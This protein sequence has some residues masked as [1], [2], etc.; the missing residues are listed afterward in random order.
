MEIVDT[1]EFLL[2]TWQVKRSIEDYRDTTRGHFE[3]IA[4]CTELPSSTERGLG[5]LARYDEDGELHFGEHRGPARRRLEYRSQKGGSVALYFSDGRAFVDLDL[6]SGE[7]HASHLCGDDQ[8]T[9]F[10][11]VS[12]PD[13]V[14]ERW[15]VHGPTKRYEAVTTLTR[16][17]PEILSSDIKRYARDQ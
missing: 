16:I 13:V 7:W 17:A 11:L 4:T 12:S 6:C 2:G 9:I 10:T 14:E 3:G 15:S 8:Y 5:S 1:F